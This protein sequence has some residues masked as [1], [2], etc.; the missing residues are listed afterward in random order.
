[1]V[2]WVVKRPASRCSPKEN[3]LFVLPYLGPPRTICSNFF[4]FYNFFH[5]NFAKIYGPQ[6][7]CKTIH[8]AP[9][10][11]AVAR[12]CSTFLPP[13]GTAVGSNLF[14]KICIFVA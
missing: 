1:M 8:L 3:G 14:S 4:F 9:W 6:K 11:T 2:W 7:N 5:I 10:G 13:W 12:Y